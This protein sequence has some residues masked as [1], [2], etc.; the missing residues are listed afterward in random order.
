MKKSIL[1]GSVLLLFSGALIGQVKF[2]IK[3]GA[4]S[5]NLNTNELQIL[6]QG[7]ADRLK[8]ALDNSDL[9]I[10]GGFVIQFQFGNFI[11]QPEVYYNS[12]SSSFDVDSFSIK[13]ITKEKYQYLDVP[14]LLGYKLGP[15][16][17]MGGPVGHVFLSST[18]GLFDFEGYEQDFK[19][20]TL[21]WQ[22]GIGLDIWKIMVDLRYEGNFSKFGNHINFFGNQY[23]FDKSPSSFVLSLAWTFGGN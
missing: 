8:I 20:L 4:S 23:E 13:Q 1:I 6:D 2:G 15:L 11:V 7:G 5:T 16:R 14:V 10:F 9:G 18:S 21:G 22:A 12:N 19:D 17:L 3:A